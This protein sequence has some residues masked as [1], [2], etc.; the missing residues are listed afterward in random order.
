MEIGIIGIGSITIDIAHR[1]VQAGHSVLITHPSGNNNTLRDLAQ[2]MGENVKL[3]T[4]KQA[5]IAKIVILFVKRAELQH[6]IR[7]LPDMTKKIILHTNNPFFHKIHF[8][9]LENPKSSYEMLSSLLPRAHIV[10]IFNPLYNENNQDKIEVFITGNNQ[11]AK[12]CAKLFLETLNLS[13]VDISQSHAVVSY[14]HNF[15]PKGV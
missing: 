7:E 4:V 2:K 3:V 13:P 10:K 15:F 9:S 1:A 11:M 14:K 6:V 8:S 12:K 5:A